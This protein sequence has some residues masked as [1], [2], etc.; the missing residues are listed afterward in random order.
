MEFVLDAV[1]GFFGGV[2]A[3]LRRNRKAGQAAG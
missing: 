2:F 1:I 3:K